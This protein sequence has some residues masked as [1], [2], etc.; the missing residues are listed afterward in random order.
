MRSPT[1]REGLEEWWARERREGA[2]VRE[3][4]GVWR[5]VEKIG[6]ASGGGG[7][8]GGGGGIRRERGDD[9]ETR[10]RGW[11]REVVGVLKGH[12]VSATTTTTNTAASATA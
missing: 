3:E 11:A 4:E 7:G 12:V 2:W 6:T 9:A 8:E 5:V 10:M 1:L